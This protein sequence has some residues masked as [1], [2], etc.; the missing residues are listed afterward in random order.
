MANAANHFEVGAGSCGK[1]V[2]VGHDGDHLEALLEPERRDLGV[3]QNG[4]C[5][6]GLFSSGCNL[7][8]RLIK[9]GLAVIVAGRK[10][11]G[12]RQ[13]KGTDKDRIDTG[14]RGYGI[15]LFLGLRRLDH[16]DDSDAR[17]SGDEIAWAIT[18]T[19]ADGT[20][21][22]ATSGGIETGIDSAAGLFG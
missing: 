15:D 13:I 5:N 19:H 9:G 7:A 3:G 11:K 14:G 4:R 1:G 21:A 16:G 12:D 2:D 8:D 17:I 18:Q 10:A 6:A 20:K 22:A